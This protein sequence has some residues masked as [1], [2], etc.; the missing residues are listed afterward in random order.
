MNIAFVGSS[1][2][3][4]PLLQEAS[5][6]SDQPLPA[7]LLQG[8]LRER[9]IETG[10]TLRLAS[11]AED[12][13]LDQTNSIVVIA[14]E[15]CDEILR[16]TRAAVQAE[17]HVVV[18]LPELTASAALTFELQ[19]ILDE[20]QTAIIPI[21]GRWLLPQLPTDRLTLQLQ[22]DIIRQL[23]LELP[24]H[25]LNEASLNT[26]LRNGL[27]LLTASGFLYSQVTCLDQAVPGGGLISRMVS[28][29]TQPEAERL[30]PPAALTLRPATSTDVGQSPRLIVIQ[31]D[32]Q[33][34][35]FAVTATP[36]LPRIRHLTAQRQEC[37]AWLDAASATLELC[38]ATARSI[39]RRRTVDVHFDAGT[40]RSVFKSQMTALGCGVLTWLLLGM[41][42]YLIAGQL[43]TLP[44]WAWHTARI[45]WMVPLGIFLIAQLLLPL[46]R[47]RG[48]QTRGGQSANDGP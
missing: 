35:Q 23:T 36:L 45:L 22:A 9:A 29:S 46:T 30:L 17:K 48:G 25:D 37:T 19:L 16:L 47:N 24:L 32:G 38:E 33:Q 26:G 10:I 15:D 39:R 3:A 5:R 6:V 21:L 12:V 4:W 27:D 28:L 8:A 40:E 20:S 44:G 31:R 42:A 2:S 41:V 1:L 14:V 34:Q 7:S 13:L 43:L 11:S 18:V